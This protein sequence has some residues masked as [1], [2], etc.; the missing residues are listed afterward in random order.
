MKITLDEIRP[1]QGGAAGSMKVRIK[2]RLPEDSGRPLNE[3]SLDTYVNK[4]IQAIDDIQ[5]H[6]LLKTRSLL[7]EVLNG[8]PKPTK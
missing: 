1:K 4:S 6:A 5:T 8:L 2:I 7:E 3:I